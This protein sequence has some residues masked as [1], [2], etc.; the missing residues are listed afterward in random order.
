[1]KGY[2]LFSFYTKMADRVSVT[3]RTGYGERVGN[4]FKKI[5]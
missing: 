3:T 1:M 5:F 2:F 4:S